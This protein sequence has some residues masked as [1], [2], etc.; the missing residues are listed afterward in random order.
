VL[1]KIWFWAAVFWTVFV[2]VI[3]LI[4][5]PDLPEVGVDSADKYVHA[6]VHFIFSIVWALHFRSRGK[7]SLQYLLIAVFIMSLVFGVLIEIAQN[8]LTDTR[9][10][11]V[12]DIAANCAGALLA[13]ITILL[14][15][16]MRSKT[17]T[18]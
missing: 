5:V 16:R 12:R 17:M 18:I 14:Y 7:W 8:F 4:T 1:N 3:C 13:I 11:D 10:A 6:S 15:D 2:A 9:T